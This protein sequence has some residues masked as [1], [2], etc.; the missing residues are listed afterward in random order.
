MKIS[1]KTGVTILLVT[2][3]VISAWLLSRPPVTS[4]AAATSIF[5]ALSSNRGNGILPLLLPEEQKALGLTKDQSEKI[6]TEVI[7]PAFKALNVDIKDKK[8]LPGPYETYFMAPCHVGNVEG[9]FTLGILELSTGV[10]QTSLTN[11]YQ[12][13]VMAE[14][15]IGKKSGKERQ[16]A[17][18]L[19]QL[20][21][22]L[23]EHG[24]KGLY[25]HRDKTIS[26]L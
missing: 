22:N 17:T 13:L 25:S 12:G 9:Q 4:T 6:L 3:F 20:K 21:S 24:M 15:G 8:F 26:T 2:P 5:D 23:I 10:F 14:V 16:V 7:S 18:R 19:Q 11:L 1:K